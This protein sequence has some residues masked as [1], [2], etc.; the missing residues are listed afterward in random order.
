VLVDLEYVN[1]ILRKPVKISP[2]YSIN[3]R[4]ENE[5]KTPMF[6]KW[7]AKLVAKEVER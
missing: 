7:Y 5:Y 3:Q 6:K 2:K 4:L 1:K